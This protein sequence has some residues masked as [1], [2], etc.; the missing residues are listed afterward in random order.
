VAHRPEG[1]RT[2]LETFQREHA[3]IYD[4]IAAADSPAARE[5]MRAHLDNSQARYRRLANE[6]SKPAADAVSPT[7]TKQRR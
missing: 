3:A 1:Q 6:M 2:Y 5:T 4:A 7:A